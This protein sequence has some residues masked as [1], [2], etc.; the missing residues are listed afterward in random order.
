MAGALL[1]SDRAAHALPHF[2]QVANGTS[3]D[4]PAL[5]YLQGIPVMEIRAN[6]NTDA[7]WF[8]IN[9]GSWQIVTS[10]TTKAA[11]ALVSFQG[12]VVSV[13][14]GE[15]GNFYFMPLSNTTSSPASWTFNASWQQIPGSNGGVKTNLRAS[16]VAAGNKLYLLATFADQSIRFTTATLDGSGNVAWS[17]VYNIVPGNGFTNSS[18][19]AV[20]AN[21][22]L[23]VIQTGTDGTSYATTLNLATNQ[24][25][26]NW[27]T[28]NGGFFT[29]LAFGTTAS[30]ISTDGQLA[31]CGTDKNVLRIDCGQLLVTPSGSGFQYSVTLHPVAD[32]GLQFT[33]HS[34][35]IAFDSGNV[36]SIAATINNQTTGQPEVMLSNQ[37]TFSAMVSPQ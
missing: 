2:H 30:I 4:S 26:P 16:L 34:P 14:T 36:I 12:K 35:T 32:N 29:N 1:F 3:S 15:D 37:Q 18:V 7:L 9:Q 33:E 5:T 17:G 8:S 21:N 22:F 6:D 13:H 31:F 28:M 27:S 25:A 20:A 10:G 11:P 23:T 19:S 24:W